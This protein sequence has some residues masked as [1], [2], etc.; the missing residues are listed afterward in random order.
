MNR[1]ITF[2]KK[3]II[4]ITAAGMVV[5]FIVFGIIYKAAE[6]PPKTYLKIMDKRVDLQVMNVHYTEATDEGIKWEIKADSAQY[7]KKENIALFKNPNI[8]LMMPDGRE[9]VLTGSE[10]CL[11][12]DSKNI[13]ISGNINLISNNGDLF[14]T[15]YMNYSGA[16][17][18]C[19]T[20]AQVSMK[21]GKIQIEAK[22]MSLSLKN[23][24]LTLSSRVKA[25]L[26]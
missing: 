4:V 1:F 7:R 19:Y 18:R 5:L 22:G 26:N 6:S 11:H 9:F 8:K 3:K 23:E 15:D 2:G 10:G 13:E 12:E 16:E 20:D 17:K 21:N 24:H 25:C 14:K